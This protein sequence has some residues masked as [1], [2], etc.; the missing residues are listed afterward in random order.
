[1][2]S[3]Q[4]LPLL[5]LGSEGVLIETTFLF[6]ENVLVNSYQATVVS[7]EGLRKIY[8]SR[9]LSENNV[10]FLLTNCCFADIKFVL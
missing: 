5:P 9:Q 1:M 2:I 8:Y 7:K 4:L 10:L 3:F 6:E